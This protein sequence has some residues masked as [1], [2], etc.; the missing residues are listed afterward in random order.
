MKMVTVKVLY[1]NFVSAEPVVGEIW[2][3]CVLALNLGRCSSVCRQCEGDY[4]F[5]HYDQGDQLSGYPGKLEK[6]SKM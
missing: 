5:N 2:Q 3:R 4:L 1:G 6:S